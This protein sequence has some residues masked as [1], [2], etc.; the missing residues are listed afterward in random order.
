M[1]LTSNSLSKATVTP[2]LQPLFRPKG[3]AFRLAEAEMQ[4]KQGGGLVCVSRVP[5]IHE[6]AH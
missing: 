5:E 6:T 1:W 2:S 3:L 4:G